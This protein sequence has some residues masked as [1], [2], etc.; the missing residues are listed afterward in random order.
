VKRWSKAAVIGALL[1]A[2]AAQGVCRERITR[3]IDFYEAARPIPVW[4]RIVYGIA[5]A[6]HDPVK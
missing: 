6:T 5:V 1:A 3:F 4:E 2:A